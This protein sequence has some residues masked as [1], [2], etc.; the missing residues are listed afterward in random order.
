MARPPTH[1]ARCRPRVEAIAL[2]L[3]AAACGGGTLVTLG[4]RPPPPPRFQPP[5]PVAGLESDNKDDNPT[6]TAD[7]LQIYF[8]SGR[9]Q[10]GSKSDV[11]FARRT[12][13]ADPFDAPEELAGLNST[14]FESSSAISLDGLTLWFG[15][16]RSGDMDIYV[17]TRPS[18]G[19]AWSAPVTVPALNSTGLD[20]P[21]P[22]GLGGRVMPLGTTRDND[23]VYRTFFAA[24]ADATAA[25]GTP[26]PLLGS[27]LEDQPTVDGF[28]TDDGLALFYS[29]PPGGSGD[30]YVARRHSIHEPFSVVQP[31]D[32]LN[33]AADERDPW[34]SP[35]GTRFFFTSDRGNNFGLYEAT[36]TSFTH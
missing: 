10:A 25:W 33:T 5:H 30:L 28:L 19:A 34:M 14:E 15:S 7:L 9:A 21:R 12:S 29:S 18:L 6:L 17:S 27:V 1:R 2:A 20:I 8:T 4:E 26:Q 31:L 36:V 16:D 11:W 13:A 23:G 32:D 3:A 24:R 22:P 35:D